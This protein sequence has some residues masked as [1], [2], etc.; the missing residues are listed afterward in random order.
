MNNLVLVEGIQNADKDQD[1]DTEEGP[2][3]LST[4]KNSGLGTHNSRP[5]HS[6]W[7]LRVRHAVRRFVASPLATATSQSVRFTLISGDV[8]SACR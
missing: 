6:E 2:Y 7:A 4:G 1:T 3:P 5:T 8:Y